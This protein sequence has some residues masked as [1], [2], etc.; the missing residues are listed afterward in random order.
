MILGRESEV[1]Y[2]NMH[3][4]QDDSRIMVVYGEKNVGK[5]A[6]LHQFVRDKSF[7]YHCAKYVSLREQRYQW[8]AELKKKGIRLPEYPEF[9]DIFKSLMGNEKKKKVIIVDEFQNMVKAG[10]EFIRQLIWFVHE[11]QASCQVMIVLCS[12]SI[13]WVE[14]NMVTKIGEAAYELSGLLKI[15]AL[16]FETLREYFAGFSMEQSIEAYAVL[17]GMPGLLKQF[18][19]KLSIKENICRYILNRNAFLYEEGQ[20]IAAQEL[21]EMGVYNTI[22]AALA[23]GRHKLNDLH[24]HT[25]FS[26]A[27]ISVYLKN[28]MELEFVEKVFSYDTE[29]KANTQK[30]IYRISNHFVHFYFTY[31]YPNLSSLEQMEPLEFYNC[32]IE[33]SFKYY[34]AE[35]FKSVCRQYIEKWNKWGKLPFEIEK[36]GEWV[37][38]F[39]TIDVIAQNE[40]GRTIAGICNWDNPMMRYDDYEW[41][42]FCLKKAKLQADYIYLFSSNRFDEKLRLEAAVKQ[43]LKLISLDEM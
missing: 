25:E 5:T 9:T 19:D 7:Y 42:L 3:F 16:G 18:D 36:T 40:E 8:G 31:I 20:R 24:L 27:K 6:L 11:I 1:N 4:D 17:G 13:G 28:L 30:G 12:S 29:G 38:K 39:G 34:V 23:S 10:D 14:N 35:Y 32:Y 33:P 26:R 41:L 43:N 15:R 21:R 2:L 22:L 37:G